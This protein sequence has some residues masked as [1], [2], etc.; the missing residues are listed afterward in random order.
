MKKRICDKCKKEI[1]GAYYKVTRNEYVD[2]RMKVE[3]LYDLC[4][5]CI[6]K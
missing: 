1:L 3:N 2:K 5:K 4:S 6:D